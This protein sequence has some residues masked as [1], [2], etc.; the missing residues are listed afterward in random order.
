MNK[1]PDVSVVLPCRNEEETI[2]ACIEKIKRVFAD[3]GING[4]IIVSDSSTDKSPQIAESLGARVIRHG[5]EGYGVAC[6]EGFKHAKGKYV[7]VGDADDTYDFR[8]MPKFLKPLRE[9]CDLV[10]GTRIK[11]RIMPGAM[12]WLHRYVGNPLLSWLLNLFFHTNVSDAHC[13]MR[14]FT[15]EALE[16]M[17][18]KTA[19]MEFASEM[20]I[21][22]AKRKL[23]MTEVP[24]TYYPRRGKSKLNSF[25]DG[26]DHLRL[27]LLYSPDHLFLLPGFLLFTAGLFL[28]ILLLK[29]PARILGLNWY[30][31]PMV[32]GSLL[33]ILGYQ[34][35]LLGLYAK[36]YAVATGFEEYDRLAYFFRKNITVEKGSIIGLVLFTAGFAINAKIL[37]TWIATGFGE[38]SEMK[39]A[40][41]AMTLTVVGV[42][43]IFHSFF[44]SMLMMNRK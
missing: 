20:I 11:G 19:G 33:T 8:E 3:E 17:N 7:V 41:F 21:M 26:W 2:G 22:A 34:I 28:M 38:L 32:L 35:I 27:M 44:L 42:Q 29:G 25:S 14:S 24:I 31:H 5:R 13:G 12:P 39:S 37:Y 30:I 40:I 16:G 9:G 18:L 15:R 1:T 43:T 10:V 4:E 23:R 6:L 36:T